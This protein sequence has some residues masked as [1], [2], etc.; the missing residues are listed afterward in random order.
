MLHIRQV[1][2]LNRMAIAVV[3]AL[4]AVLASA[5][6]PKAQMAPPRPSLPPQLGGQ[7]ADLF[8]GIESLF[9]GIGL[10]PDIQSQVNCATADEQQHD[11]GQGSDVGEDIEINIDSDRAGDRDRDG[12]RASVRGAPRLML[13]AR[14][15]SDRTLP[16]R[17]RLSGRLVPPMGLVR[18]AELFQALGVDVRPQACNGRVTITFKARG[19]TVVKRRASVTGTC[20]FT[21]RVTIRTRRRLGRSRRLTASARFGGN[22]RLAPVRRSI[23][24]PI[25]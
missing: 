21:S 17:F 10:P 5:S 22:R 6:A 18:V 8:P 12:G 3:L 4:S 20:R 16:L 14:P 23:K 11:C 2:L 19:R 1:A 7:L 24:L 9:P 13:S 25:G 15:R